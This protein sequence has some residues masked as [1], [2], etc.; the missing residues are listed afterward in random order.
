MPHILVV[1]DE[2]HLAFGRAYR[3]A[4]GAHWERERNRRGGRRRRR[5][6]RD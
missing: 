1:D 2:D 6:G 4:F 3:Y 5:R